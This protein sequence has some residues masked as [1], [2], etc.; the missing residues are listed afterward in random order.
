MKSYFIMSTIILS[1]TMW[2]VV[3]ALIDIK[4]ELKELNNNLKHKQYNEET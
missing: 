4:N 2:G 3:M 1:I